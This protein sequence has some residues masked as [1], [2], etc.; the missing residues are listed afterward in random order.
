MKERNITNNYLWLLGVVPRTLTNGEPE[1]VFKV[2]HQRI[3]FDQRGDITRKLTVKHV[4]TVAKQVNTHWQLQEFDVSH[5]K[6]TP[7]PQ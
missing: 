4:P 6:D 2:L 3:Y 1:K 7:Q 5:E